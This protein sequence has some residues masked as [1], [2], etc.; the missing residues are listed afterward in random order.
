[1]LQLTAGTF[2]QHEFTSEHGS[3]LY[4]L[5][6]PSSYDAQQP[7]PLVVMLHGCTQDGQDSARG[8]RLNEHA[9]RLGF[10]VVYPEQPQSA[11]P[12]KCWNWFDAKHQSRDAGEPA[13]L[14]GITREVLGKYRIDPHRVF[15]A[16][17]SAGAAMANIVAI[18]YPELFAA[19]GLHAG[20]EYKAATTVLNARIAMNKG[21]PDPVQ[22]GELAFAA[23]GE[24]ARFFPV[25]IANGEQDQSVPPLHVKQLATQWRTIHGMIGVEYHE[26]VTEDHDAGDPG[27]SYTT[28]KALGKDG[29][30]LLQTVLVSNLGH[31][32]SGGSADGS[33][34]DP[35]GPDMIAHMVRFLF[36]VVK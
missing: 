22:Q 31:A 27:Y 34:T 29:R 25:F 5:Y 4:W 7:V 3:R 24:R 1:M 33:Y 20:M 12:L 36:D 10:I 30:V 21:G 14:A 11:N 15:L 6:T 8:S 2:T 23:M 9:E 19:V 17:M 32:L 13:L 18:S 28:T 16:G 35:K 26:S